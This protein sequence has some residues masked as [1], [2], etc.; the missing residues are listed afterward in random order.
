LEATRECL[1]TKTKRVSGKPR[2]VRTMREKTKTSNQ[3]VD[4]DQGARPVHCNK[5]G[6]PGTQK[7]RKVRR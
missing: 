7:L 1:N 6:K 4:L 3:E 5:T 2:E